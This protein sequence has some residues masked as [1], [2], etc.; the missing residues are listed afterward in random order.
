MKAHNQETTKLPGRLLQLF[1]S[2]YKIPRGDATSCR[3]KAKEER[4]ELGDIGNTSL[5]QTG[6]SQG[7]P[8]RQSS[9]SLEVC[10]QSQED[11]AESEHMSKE[12]SRLRHW[13]SVVEQFLTLEW[14]LFICSEPHTNP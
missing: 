6:S 8:E 2:M 4:R 12:S 11:P 5:E 7:C 14:H 3:T 13:D 9:Q 1:K 10:K